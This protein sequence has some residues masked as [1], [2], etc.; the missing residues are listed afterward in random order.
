MVRGKRWMCICAGGNA[1]QCNALYGWAKILC[2]DV[3][4][5]WMGYSRLPFA[6]I[7]SK[8][9]ESGLLMLLAGFLADFVNNSNLR[10]NVY[11]VSF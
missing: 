6:C 3:L 9:E 1:M 4:R 10:I 5:G 7:K 8:C 11:I 2:C